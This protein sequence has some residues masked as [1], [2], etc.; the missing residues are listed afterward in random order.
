MIERVLILSDNENLTLR[1]LNENGPHAKTDTE[2]LS[3][4]CV[5][6]NQI[7]TAL[8]DFDFTPDERTCKHFGTWPFGRERGD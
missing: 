5:Y 1:Y 4:Y 6:M 3:R 2:H 8:E 7:L